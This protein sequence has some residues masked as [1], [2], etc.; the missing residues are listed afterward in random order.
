MHRI[1]L[2]RTFGIKGTNGTNYSICVTA[3]R[4]PEHLL[5]GVDSKM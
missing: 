4:Q 5:Q 1:A 3:V 2:I